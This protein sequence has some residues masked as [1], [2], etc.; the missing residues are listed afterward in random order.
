MT[1]FTG[2]CLLALSILVA[3]CHKTQPS[4]AVRPGNLDLGACLS[5]TFGDEQVTI[6]LEEV[7]SDSRCA[8][9]ATCVWA[10][11]AVARFKFT[12]GGQT[13]N[14]I[15]ATFPFANYAS[16]TNI[17]SYQIQFINLYPVP[18]LDSPAP[19]PGTKPRAEVKITRI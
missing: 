8:I 17:A 15:L 3:S 5:Q 7:I 12:Q 6:C 1:K 11:S 14:F 13:H 4:N 9:G 18:Q 19:V 2:I 10:G 16:S